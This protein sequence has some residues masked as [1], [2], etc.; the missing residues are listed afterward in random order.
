MNNFVFEHPSVFLLLFLIIC[1]YK[2]PV[3]IKQIVF[4]HTHLFRKITSWI[5]KEKLLYSLVFALLITA[6]ASPISYDTK[7]SQDRKGR[8]LVFVLDASGSMGEVGYSKEHKDTNKFKLL[9]NIIRNFIRHRYDDNIGV[10]VFGTYAFASVPLTYDMKSVSFL[11]DFLDVG[12]A[13]E[14][15]AIGDG[16]DKATSLLKKGDAKNK[17]I[18]LV[19]DGHQNSGTISIK[20]AVAHAKKQHIKIYT[21]GIGNKNDFDATL[22]KKIAT[23]TNAKMFTAVDESALQ[24]VYKEL[25]SLEPSKIRSK[26]YLNKHTLFTYPLSFAILLLLYLLNK[27][28]VL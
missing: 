22:L 25:D 28:R 12:I 9:K 27:R 1:I 16:I 21:I 5:D 23:D 20:D 7:L 11:L 18:I 15:T 13:G 26:H 10:V 3:K 6:L 19:T 8:D 4:P 17:V 14:N 24:E 2:C